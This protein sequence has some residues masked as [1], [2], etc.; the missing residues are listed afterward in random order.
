[1]IRGKGEVSAS[2]QSGQV[3]TRR[4]PRTKVAEMVCHSFRERSRWRDRAFRNA[5]TYVCR[6]T[7]ELGPWTCGHNGRLPLRAE[8]RLE[9][10]KLENMTNWIRSLVHV[11][12]AFPCE[13]TQ[14]DRISPRTWRESRL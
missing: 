3:R 5:G 1:M 10:G 9:T 14:I 13:N 12:S 8:K 11:Y 4:L 7:V 6:N 2:M